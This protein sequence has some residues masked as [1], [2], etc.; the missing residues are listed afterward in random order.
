MISARALT[1]VLAKASYEQLREK[2]N[3]GTPGPDASAP[4]KAKLVDKLAKQA[5]K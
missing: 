3:G 2:A 4:E 1:K 5:F